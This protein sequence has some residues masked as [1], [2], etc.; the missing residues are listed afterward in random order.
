MTA[1]RF[2]SIFIILLMFFISSCV[3][4][5]VGKM[6]IPGTDTQ[7]FLEM[8]I[9]PVE[10]TE[11]FKKKDV[12]RAIQTFYTEWANEFGEDSKVHSALEAVR[13]EF[14]KDKIYVK[15]GYSINGKPFKSRYCLGVT[16]DIDHAQIWVRKPPY[17]ISKTSLV[18][19]LIH[20]SLKAST[21]MYD[22]DHLGNKYKAW[23][24]KHN[25]FLIK[26]RAI[27]KKRSL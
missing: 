8:E 18:H 21:G 25:K 10:D 6:T 11:T 17:K 22:V 9:K 12:D 23:T 2:L 4:V 1:E 24:R 19:E 14:T 13:I 16:K 15:S 27:L 7:I 26:T 20:I 3:A 5:G